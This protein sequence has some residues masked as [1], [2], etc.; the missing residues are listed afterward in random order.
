MATSRYRP[1]KVTKAD[2]ERAAQ[3]LRSMGTKPIAV[4][5]SRDCVRIVTTEGK[6]LTLDG[7][8]ENLDQELAEWAALHG[9]G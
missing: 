4:E 7:D 9:Q 1:A 6:N 3:F 8:K 2:Y 5:I